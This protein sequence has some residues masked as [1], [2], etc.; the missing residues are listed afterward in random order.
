MAVCAPY[1]AERR[2]AAASRSRDRS[3]SNRDERSR[4]AGGCRARAG[5]PSDRSR[6]RRLRDHYRCLLG[7]RTLP[8]VA[9]PTGRSGSFTCLTHLDLA[10]G[11]P[12]QCPR[13]RRTT[14]GDRSGKGLSSPEISVD[15]RTIP[16]CARVCQPSSDLR[17]CAS[18]QVS[19]PYR[20][21]AATDKSQ[22]K[23]LLRRERCHCV[24][25]SSGCCDPATFGAS[26]TRRPSPRSRAIGSPDLCRATASSPTPNCGGQSL[27]FSQRQA[28]RASGTPDQPGRRKLPRSSSP[29]P[30]AGAGRAPCA[31]DLRGVA[32]TGRG[33][34]LVTLGATGARRRSGRAAE[35][36]G[37]PQGAVLVDQRS[38]RRSGCRPHAR[39][40]PGAQA[41]P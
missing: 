25:C 7:A 24:A 38:R 9:P 29:R 13:G 35:H 33:V 32:T 34:T 19:D 16:G 1:N 3:G 2:H 10:P 39:C 5:R 27:G 8:G 6:S 23:T 37:D 30:A 12:A 20:G 41:T 40:S 28:G 18:S 15:A 17:R 36:L 22:Q 26:R 31:V 4:A 11:R 21:A 14:Q